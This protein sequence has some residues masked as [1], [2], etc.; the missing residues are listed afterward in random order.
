M[1]TLHW[2]LV[3]INTIISFFFFNDTATTEI[4]TLSLHDAL[5]ICTTEVWTELNNIFFSKI[6]TFIILLPPSSPNQNVCKTV[7]KIKLV[8]PYIPVRK[9]DSSLQQ[10]MD[11]FLS[12]LLNSFK[13]WFIKCRTT[14]LSYPIKNKKCKND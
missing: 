12:K 10:M 9:K 1:S 13:V 3:G 8:W 14:K 6:L 5:P 7:I 4:Y 11:R 2:L